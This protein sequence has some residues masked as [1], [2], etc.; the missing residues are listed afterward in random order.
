FVVVVR[1]DENVTYQDA[2]QNGAERQLQI[3]VVAFVEAFAWRTEKSGGARFRRDDRSEHGPPWDCATAEHEIFEAFFLPAHVK[4]DGNDDDEIKE[5]NCGID[6]E[7][8][9]HV[10]GIYQ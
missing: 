7:P 3:S 10:A 5:Q 4:A 8:S 1:L 6:R 9:V 2:R